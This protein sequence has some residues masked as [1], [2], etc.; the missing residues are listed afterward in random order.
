MADLQ[1]LYRA[2]KQHANQAVAADKRHDLVAA[3]QCYVDAVAALKTIAEREPNPDKAGKVTQA[4]FRYLE[5]AE[6]LAN[7]IDQQGFRGKANA[8]PAPQP[9][10]TGRRKDSHHSPQPAVNQ[11][12][13][14]PK[15]LSSLLA[16]DTVQGSRE[17]AFIR[18][19]TIEI[20]GRTFTGSFACPGSEI[21]AVLQRLLSGAGGVDGLPE[22]GFGDPGFNVAR[23]GHGKR[24]ASGT[25]RQDRPPSPHHDEHTAVPD[26][27]SAALRHQ[28]NSTRVHG[29]QVDENGRIVGAQ[30]DFHQDM[31]VQRPDKPDSGVFYRDQDWGELVRAAK[32]K[33]GPPQEPVHEKIRLSDRQAQI[34]AS[35]EATRVNPASQHRG[36]SLDGFENEVYIDP[37]RSLSQPLPKGKAPVQAKPQAAKAAIM[38]ETTALGAKIRNT[39]KVGGERV[40][41]MD[42]FVASVETPSV[43]VKLPDVAPLVAEL[44]MQGLEPI[45]VPSGYSSSGAGESGAASEGTFELQVQPQFRQ[46][47]GSVPKLVVQHAQAFEYVVTTVL[48]LLGLSTQ[49]TWAMC[50]MATMRADVSV[51]SK[52]KEDGLVYYN[53]MAFQQEQPLNEAGALRHTKRLWRYWLQRSAMATSTND[54]PTGLYDPAIRARFAHFLKQV[55]ET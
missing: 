52:S 19:L 37:D 12:P 53:L 47:D 31:A 7:V 28:N 38:F 50:Y 42:H 13:S 4:A 23:P 41:E 15:P 36:Y 32:G 18:N 24:Q 1:Q 30:D 20:D 43:S 49:G 21:H 3:K 11:D 33:M 17:K 54:Q 5:R 22:P 8:T 39:H 46:A 6:Q 10:S 55:G 14:I 40:K 48:G 44:T 16:M 51:C 45:R 26:G 25:D 2:A 9:A 27:Q 34:E 35:R 29:V